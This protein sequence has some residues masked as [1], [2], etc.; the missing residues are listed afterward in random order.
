MRA[1]EM[2][3]TGRIVKGYIWLMAGILVS[4]LFAMFWTYGADREEGIFFIGDFYQF[5]QELKEFETDSCVYDADKD[6]FIVQQP[7]ARLRIPVKS[8]NRDWNYFVCNLENMTNLYLY[9]DVLVYDKSDEVLLQSPVTITTRRNAIPITTGEKL[10][11]IELVLYNQQGAE[12]KLEKM[13]LCE[14]QFDME[15]FLKK[16]ATILLFYFILTIILMHVKKLS[17]EGVVDIFQNAYILIGDV[18]GSRLS[19]RLS[20]NA[21]RKLQTHC[22]T[23]LFLMMIAMNVICGTKHYDT[24]RYWV[25]GFGILVAFTGVLSWEKPLQKLSWGGIITYSWF[26]LWVMVCISDLFVR[27]SFSYTGYI[28]MICMGFSFFV[29]HNEGG[30]EQTMYRLQKGLRRTLP[31]ILIYCLVFR[32]RKFGILY[33]GCFR[34]RESMALYV[35]AL[36]IVFLVEVARL[37]HQKKISAIRLTANVAGAAISCYYIYIT[38]VEACM[39][40][41]GIVSI[42]CLLQ[43]GLQ[44]RILLKRWKELLGSVAIAAA[45]AVVCVFGVHFLHG[46]LPIQ[47]KTDIVYETDRYETKLSKKMIDTMEQ[48]YP[49]WSEIVAVADEP[50]RGEVWSKYVEKWDLMGNEQARKLDGERVYAYNGIVQMMY[51]Y[52][53]FIFIPYSLLMLTGT[54]AMLRTRNFYPVAVAVSF[55]VLVFVQNIEVPFAT[56]LWLMMYLGMGRFF[57]E[58]DS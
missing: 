24:G 53:I 6:A 30:F 35:L 5:E 48:N 33:N 21:R 27:K 29:W 8:G 14:R 38:K 47:L 52:G 12:F 43:Q 55:V 2:R 22:F 23:I 57:L 49:G 25:I 56:P 42:L 28:M 26:L 46:F 58:K 3:K 37:L 15:D 1:E 32:Q 19:M 31:L 45:C 4:L 11:A 39:L 10:G 20:A 17:L 13:H 34:D 54:H 44:W 40:A 7:E 18:A 36:L 41:A 51:Q 9:C 16:A 50:G